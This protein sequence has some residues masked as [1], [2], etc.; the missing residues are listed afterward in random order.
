MYF[1]SFTCLETQTRMVNLDKIKTKPI[2]MCIDIDIAI[3][4]SFHQESVPLRVSTGGIFVSKNCAF[5][6]SPPTACK[7]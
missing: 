3:V 5:G 6:G 4:N 2:G 7:I 1:Y